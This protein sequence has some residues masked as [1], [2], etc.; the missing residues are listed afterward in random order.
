MSVLRLA[1][2]RARLAES[3]P[4]LMR[5]IEAA[6]ART[7]RPVG[8]SE[9]LLA[10]MDLDD[11]G[12]CPLRRQLLP[13]ASELEPDHPL[14]RFDPLAEGR[15]RVTPGL[16]KRYPDRALL[17]ATARCSIYCA[18]CTRSWAVG[19]GDQARWREAWEPSLAALAADPTIVDV[20]LSGGDL[21]CVPPER[22]RFLGE[23]LLA[24]PQLERLRLA[25]RGPVADP[26]LA[27]GD[28]PMLA[29][30]SALAARARE[31]GVRIAMHL[32]IN[33]PV[34]LGAVT[35]QAC[36]RLLEAGITL[37]SQTVLLR[38]VNDDS[39]TLLALV[40]SLVRCGVQPY[41][42]Y[43]ADM[44]PGAEHLRTSLA[45]AV[46][47]EKRLRGRTAG[48][49]TPDFV[50]DLL[51]GGGK[52]Q[53]HSYERYDHSTGLAVYR[54]PVIDPQRRF[55]HADPLRE[56]APEQRA[57]WLD[58]KQRAGILEAAIGVQV[59]TLPTPEAPSGP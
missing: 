34:E 39:D 6:A 12:A 17:L 40:R 4:D 7:G 16:V 30:L 8:V 13:L 50:C 23:R 14:C 48:F 43:T 54:S 9:H 56:L 53:V 36:D 26:S 29:S 35:R 59:P 24:L 42:V 2:L 31:R 58:P 27:L 55:L 47:L 41:Y 11:P 57:A 22:L 49:D 37:R 51:G 25:S 20:T 52:R 32:H 46:E 18:F 3:R 10:L 28:S 44:A 38:G 1:A 5:E 15:D 45:S 19:R 33:H 21:W